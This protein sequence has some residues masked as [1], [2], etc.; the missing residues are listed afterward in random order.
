[1]RD[2]YFVTPLGDGRYW[3]GSGY[4]WGEWDTEVNTEDIEKMLQFA[5]DR[6][7]FSFQEVGRLAGIRPAMRTR[8]PVMGE[9]PE[10]KSWYIFNGLG[11]KGTSLGPY[12]AKQMADY[13]TT[14]APISEEVNISRYKY[15]SDKK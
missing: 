10:Q 15:P 4:R 5:H 3:I 14:K 13:L 11:T 1:M 8:R 9:H 12:F 6:L 7:A 2:E